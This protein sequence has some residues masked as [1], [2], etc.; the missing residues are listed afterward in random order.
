MTNAA[1][2]KRTMLIVPLVLLVVV[3]LEDIAV[4][5]IR[6]HIRDVEVRAAMVMLL[7]GVGFAI[8]ALWVAPRIK[9]LLVSG[10]RGS[11]WAGGKLGI[12]LFYAIAYGA[13]YLAFLQLERHGAAG[14]LP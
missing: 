2:P 14:L 7:Q 11:R 1:F 5:K 9:D 6:Q 3:I 10:R 12:W 13:L 4:Y 8:A